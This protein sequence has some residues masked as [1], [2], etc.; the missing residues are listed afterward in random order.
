MTSTR[1]FH[2]DQIAQISINAHDLKRAEAFYRDKL[3]IKHLFT[4]PNMAFFD[5][6]GIRLMVGIPSSPD[7]DH[8]SSIIYFKVKDIQEAHQTLVAR[9]VQFVGQPFMVAQMPT[10]ELWLAEFRDSEQNVLSLM[11]EVPRKTAA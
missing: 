9:G 8:P 10:Y 11:S 7:L 3:G 2:L 4:V 1:D 6:G 5:C